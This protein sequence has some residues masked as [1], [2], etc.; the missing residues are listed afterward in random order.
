MA[1]PYVFRGM[2][3][4]PEIIQALERYVQMR[5]PVG[6]FLTALLANDLKEACGRADD[7]NLHNLPALVAYVYN[8]IPAHAWGSYER[9]AAWLTPQTIVDE[10][11]S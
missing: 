3:A 8:H 9:V 7:D 4:R 5:C 2:V 6:G 1:I 11:Q 10:A